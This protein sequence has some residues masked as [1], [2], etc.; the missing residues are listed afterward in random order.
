VRPVHIP[1]V[2][3]EYHQHIVAVGR[4]DGIQQPSDL[5]VE[6]RIAGH[7]LHSLLRVL[8]SAAH[9]EF[10]ALLA[11]LLRP[12]VSDTALLRLTV[13]GGGGKRRPFELA[14]ELRRTYKWTMRLVE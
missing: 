3:C 14:K 5:G 13:R 1:V 9:R 10:R 12:C 7:V 11:L 2:T 4:V 8:L 6:P